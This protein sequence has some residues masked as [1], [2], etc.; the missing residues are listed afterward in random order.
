MDIIRNDNEGPCIVCKRKI[1]KGEYV[2]NV[3][4]YLEKFICESD[5]K[6]FDGKLVCDDC[7]H[8]SKCENC[9]GWLEDYELSLLIYYDVDLKECV[10][11]SEHDEYILKYYDIKYKPY[12][13]D[14]IEKIH[15]INEFLHNNRF[16]DIDDLEETINGILL[17]NRILD[18]K[19]KKLIKENEFLRKKNKDNEN[20][21][22]K[23]NEKFN[24]KNIED[25]NIKTN[26]KDNYLE[27]I[28]SETEEEKI[29]RLEKEKQER[30]KNLRKKINKNIIK[31]KVLNN[32]A[33]LN[34]NSEKIYKNYNL[35][36]IKTKAFSSLKQLYKDKQL[37]DK[38]INTINKYK[39]IK[40]K[41]N[42]IK[43][44][45]LE[46]NRSKINLLSILYKKKELDKTL[47]KDDFELA[48]NQHKMD[49]KNRTRMFRLCKI[50]YFLRKNDIFWNSDLMIRSLYIF[51]YI[52]DYQ[53]DFLISEIEKIVQ[54]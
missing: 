20:I 10:N 33:E 5:Y 2:Y 36:L 6:E 15:N 21:I 16:D 40:F 39:C 31:S 28:F 48:L 24:E 14:T 38:S 52:K 27:Y 25:L 30:L 13:I 9:E 53:I 4:Y 26:I 37:L 23:L 8:H 19:N 41:D 17:K 50:C 12:G 43:K 3:R 11:C 34:K 32:F 7:Y 1:N 47:D 45:A 18:D 35:K 54:Q 51:E 44:C 42:E 29:I 22:K 46:E 49:D